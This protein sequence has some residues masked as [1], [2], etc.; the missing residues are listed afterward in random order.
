MG[1]MDYEWPLWNFFKGIFLSELTHACL[2]ISFISHAN[3]KC[4]QAPD[5]KETRNPTWYNNPYE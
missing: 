1:W 3:I 2:R 4:T 5:E